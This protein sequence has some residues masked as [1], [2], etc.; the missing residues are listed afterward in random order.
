MTGRNPLIGIYPGTFDPITL[1]HTDIIQRATKVVDHLVVAVH[2]APVLVQL[3]V[4]KSHLE[5]CAAE[6]DRHV[7]L[8]VEGQLVFQPWRDGGRAPSQ[9]DEIDVRSRHLQEILHL[10]RC[11]A[12]IKRQ[13]ES[14]LARLRRPWRQLEKIE[15][16]HDGKSACEWGSAFGGG[17]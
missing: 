17:T 5:E 15:G 13:R 10:A 9:L 11:H 1:G 12:L 14:L 2:Q 3:I 7:G 16:R 8:A 4:Q 6:I